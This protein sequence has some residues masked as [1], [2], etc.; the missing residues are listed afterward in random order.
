MCECSVRRL[1][2]ISVLQ[3]TA[4]KRT[5]TTHHRIKALRAARPLT[6]ARSTSPVRLSPSSWNALMTATRDDKTDRKRRHTSK[7]S[8]ADARPH[9]ILTSRRKVC[10][11]ATIPLF[12][13][14]AVGATSGGM[15][16]IVAS[17]KFPAYSLS[18][19]VGFANGEHFTESQ[20]QA[21]CSPSSKQ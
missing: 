11:G 20:S 6:R 2:Y 13:A 3:T 15:L 16:E 4:A 12:R 5:C 21:A 19:D 8:F 14:M 1:Y 10:R 18:P 7:C 17:F 9:D